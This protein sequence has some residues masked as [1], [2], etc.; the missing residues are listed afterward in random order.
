MVEKVLRF[1]YSKH[2]FILKK[3]SDLSAVMVSGG[4]KPGLPDITLT[5][6][7]DATSPGQ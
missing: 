6:R 5:A 2:T 1:I 4:A 3:D 7:E